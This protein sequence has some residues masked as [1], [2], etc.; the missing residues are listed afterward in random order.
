VTTL[1]LINPNT[2]ASITDLAL[3]TARRFAAKGTTLRAVTGAFGPRYIAS[4]IALPPARVLAQTS[5]VCAADVPNGFVY[6]LFG[7]DFRN[8][9][10][11]LP[12]RALASSSLAE[13]LR[14]EHIDYFVTRKGSP[15]DQGARP[16]SRVSGSPVIGPTRDSRRRSKARS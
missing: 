8:D 14:R 1:L 9:V 7:S 5:F 11:G 15:R 3:K 2:T 13:T 10:I 12:Q 4:R 16:H 6:A